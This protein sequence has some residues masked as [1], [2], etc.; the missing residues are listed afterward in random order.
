LGLEKQLLEKDI[1][2]R[3]QILFAFILGLSF[4]NHMTT[5]FLAPA[6]LWIYFRLSGLGKG[7]FLRIAKIT[8][9]FLLGLSIY[10]YLPI[11]SSSHP[12]FDWGHPASLERFLWHV[13][14]KQ[15]SVWMFSGWDAVQK[16]FNY[17]CN[18]FTS[19]FHYSVIICTIAG[20]IVLFRHSRRLFIFLILLFCTTVAYA[21]NYDIFD[22]DSYF[23][24][25]YFVIGWTTAFGIEFFLQKGRTLRLW[26]KGLLVA[27]L[28]AL[29]I[30][31]ISSHLN[32]VDE[33]KDS[34]PQQFVS[35]AFSSFE[36]NAVVL[37]TQWDYFISPSLYYQFVR[38]ERNDV[39]VI[40]KSLL[41]NRSW[42]FIQCAQNTPWLMDRIKPISEQFLAELYKFEH[43]L[44]FDFNFIRSVWNNLLA[45]IIEK[46][47]P[48]HPVY[49]D[50]RIDK[51]FPP[52]YK[53]TP[54]GLFLRLTKN[55]DTACYRPAMAHLDFKS[56]RGPAVEDLKK[57]YIG[58]LFMDADWLMRHG[59]A[60][61]AK[62]VINEI[63]RI[64][65]GNFSAA[66]LLKH[67]M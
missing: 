30:V 9:F 15:F 11:R 42:Y 66:L 50:I 19:E 17:Y 39:T 22:I 38:N 49:I 43:D 45:Q 20:L 14:G 13:S 4:S 37:A 63:L 27:A 41:Q 53:R 48:D 57:Y 65:P 46:A 31:Q 16:Q 8:P 47:L 60:G 44:P 58:I 10:C 51:E 64:E 26:M 52:E 2:S 56:K 33:S 7:A 36:P 62:T 23:M 3:E 35:H 24:L 5:I 29:P 18:N 54:A 25:S 59:R 21:V 1:I 28:C 12:I 32:N 55:E 67:L 6:F 61:E 40:D 34:L